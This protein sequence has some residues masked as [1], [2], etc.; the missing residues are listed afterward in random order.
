MEHNKRKH[1]LLSA[2]GSHRWIHCTPSAKLEESFG[3]KRTSTYAEEGTLAHELSELYIRKD[4]LGVI[5]DSEFDS[6]LEQIMS[7][8]LF[9]E[10][11]LDVIPIYT[12]YIEAQYNASLANNV[13]SILEIEQKL[14]LSKYIP[15]SFGTVDAVIIS[16][17]VMQIIDLKYGKGVPV[18]A[19]MNTQLMIY[20]L[21]ALE[22]YD[23]AYDIEEVE[24]TIV[25]PRIDNISTFR[26]SVTEL[27]NWANTTLKDAA[28][29][30]INGLGTLEAGDWCK[31]C[32][33]KNKCK[34]LYEQQIEIAKYEFSNPQLLSDDD[35]ADI[36]RRA[37]TFIEWINSITNYAEQKAVNENKHWPGFK[38][39]E[40]RS[41]RKWKNEDEVIKAI[42]ERIPELSDED[43]FK[44]SLKSL[45]EIER[46]L[47]K[48]RFS[49]QLS[50]MII[51]PAGKPT[52][53][54]E[55]DKRPAIGVEQAKI[56]FENE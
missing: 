22:K 40:G 9:N 38:L 20:S 54:D 12:D 19:H 49:T 24:L 10:E 27:L 14:D 36:L 26:I 47:G 17:G 51:K 8:E 6:K 25:Q 2:S 46:M 56:D 7:N 29:L 18:Y 3:E 23:A 44:S 5:D 35:I 32:S 13:F 33:V 52:L 16:D 53:V 45:T 55:T 31:F 34:A 11:M 21:G 43:I 30:A 4:I 37:P 50:D 28:D 41:N 42:K 39:V 48:K 15:E 1:A